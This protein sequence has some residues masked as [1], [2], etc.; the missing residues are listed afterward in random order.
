MGI[1]TYQNNHK[2]ADTLIIHWISIVELSTQVVS[3]YA[4]DTDVFA[5]MTLYMQI[6]TNEY[7]DMT[8]VADL[9]IKFAVR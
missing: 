1:E 8:S 9:A 5:L 2:K 7:N 3:V 6:N 4:A